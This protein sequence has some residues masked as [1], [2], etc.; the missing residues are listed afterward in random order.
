[1]VGKL[2]E[3]LLDLAQD[4]RLLVAEIV[5]IRVQRAADELQ[6][7]TRQLDHVVGH[8]YGPRGS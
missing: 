2:L 8:Q 5:E 1:V 6:L 3:Q 4:V 7:V